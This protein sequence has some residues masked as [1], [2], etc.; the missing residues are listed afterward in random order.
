VRPD[1]TAAAVM[2][3]VGA[4]CQAAAHDAAPSQELLAIV[5][6]GLRRQG[7]DG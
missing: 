7:H 2:A 1:V 5:C 6:D 4:T 3:L